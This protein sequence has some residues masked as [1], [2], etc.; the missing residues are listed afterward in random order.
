MDIIHTTIITITTNPLI[1]MEEDGGVEQW[2]TV[3]V[4]VEEVVEE[5]EVIIWEWLGTEWATVRA[6]VEVIHGLGRGHEE[7]VLVKTLGKT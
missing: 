6:S 3:V 4:E 1:R 7:R 5:V 2:I